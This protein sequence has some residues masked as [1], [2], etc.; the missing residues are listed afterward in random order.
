MS[1]GLSD[2]P[3]QPTDSLALREK[4]TSD[5]GVGVGVGG[6]KRKKSKRSKKTIRKSYKKLNKATKKQKANNAD[7][8]DVKAREQ[9][10]AQ[11]LL[12]EQGQS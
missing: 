6:K 1:L 10:L 7:S 9:G 8:G 2:G 11:A 12:Q 4:D 3:H 5:E